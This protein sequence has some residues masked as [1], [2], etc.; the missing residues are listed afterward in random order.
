MRAAIL[1]AIAAFALTLGFFQLTMAEKIAELGIWG[2]VRSSFY[3][4]V[5]AGAVA[6]GSL[7][8]GGPERVVVAILTA[9]IIIDPLMHQF[10]RLR[11]AS[12]DP[13]HVILDMAYLAAFVV[14]AVRANR[15]WTLWLC[16]FH[17]LATMSHATKALDLAIHPVVYGVM[18]VVWSYIILALLIWGTWNHQ[19]RLRTSGADPSWRSS[20]HRSARAETPLPNS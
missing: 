14:L 19:R 17:G 9:D 7:R 1:V 12:V 20:S 4:G 10:L 16:A 2:A 11:F 6:Y 8:G 13:T 15:L 3:I 18:Q 5:L